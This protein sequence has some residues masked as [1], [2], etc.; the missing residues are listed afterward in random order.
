[1]IQVAGMPFQ[2]GDLWSPGSIERII[3]QRMN[4]DTVMYS[5]QFIGELSLNLSYEKIYY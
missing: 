5:Y 3:F 2:Q 4:E 1:M